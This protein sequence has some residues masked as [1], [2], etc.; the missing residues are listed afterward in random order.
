MSKKRT[1]YLRGFP[2]RLCEAMEASDM[3]CVELGKLIQRDRKAIYMYRNGD[4]S[5]DVLTVARMCAVLHISADWL[6]FGT[7]WPSW[8]IE[9]RGGGPLGVSDEDLHEDND[10]PLRASGGRGRLGKRA[11]R[12]NRNHS[13]VCLQLAQP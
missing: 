13:G 12:T 2:E 9:G 3:N 11:R 6:L 4:V 10:R 5:P 7:S 8:E 1:G